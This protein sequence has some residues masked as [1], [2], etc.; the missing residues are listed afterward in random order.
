MLVAA[1]DC[2]QTSAQF[3]NRLTALFHLPEHDGFPDL[4]GKGNAAA[5]FIG[6]AHAEFRLPTDVE[7]TGLAVI[8]LRQRFSPGF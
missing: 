4:I 1:D 2:R 6:F 8:L 7:R 3:K 5:I